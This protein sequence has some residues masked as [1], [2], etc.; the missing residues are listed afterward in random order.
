[1]VLQINY[2]ESVWDIF[3]FSSIDNCYL[4]WGD[5]DAVPL[6]RLKKWNLRDKFS[7]RHKAFIVIPAD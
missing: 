6:K 2:K 3:G 1:M 4:N 7:W 5:I